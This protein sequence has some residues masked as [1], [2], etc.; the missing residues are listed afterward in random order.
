[1]NEIL[2]HEKKN[3]IQNH[4]ETIWL[5]ESKTWYEWKRTFSVILRLAQCLN[6]AWS[7]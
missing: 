6:I 1:M 5:I 2:S 4:N 3:Q 7:G